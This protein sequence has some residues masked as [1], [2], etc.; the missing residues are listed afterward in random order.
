MTPKS[1][2]SA[3]I[4]LIVIG[5]SLIPPRTILAATHRAN[6]N[7]YGNT[8]VGMWY[9]TL[10]DSTM[11]SLGCSPARSIKFLPLCPKPINYSGT[12]AYVTNASGYLNNDCHKSQ[13]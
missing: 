2:R 12:W 11:W 9:E 3:C 5:S 7:S 6:G 8:D 4:A 10:Y 13:T 1:L